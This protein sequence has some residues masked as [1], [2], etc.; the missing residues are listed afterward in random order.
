MMLVIFVTWLS[1]R[2]C[3][4]I[5]VLL[6]LML[7]LIL[8]TFDIL[9]PYRVHSIYGHQYFLTI[10]DDYSKATWV[11]L[12]RGKDEAKTQVQNFCALILTK[13]GKVVKCIRTDNGQECKM[14]KFYQ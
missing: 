10:V 4:L 7:V 3:P 6:V 5:L 13:F 2:D 12:L 8:Y 9:G 11:Y 1:K 14:D